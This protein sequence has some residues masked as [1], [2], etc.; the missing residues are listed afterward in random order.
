MAKR[1]N[2][3]PLG[4]KEPKPDPFSFAGESWREPER[5]ERRLR[6]V[7][8]RRNRSPAR[9][10][11]RRHRLHI[12]AVVPV[13][14]RPGFS[15]TTGL[16]LPQPKLR[17]RETPEPGETKVGSGFGLGSGSDPVM[18]VELPPLGE[19]ARGRTERRRR[20]VESGLRRRRRFEL[21]RSWKGRSERR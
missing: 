19:S 4:L 21:R 14:P 12:G 1:A 3:G 6:R 13:Q 8:S 17:R 20:R 16:A 5:R 9:S 18:A 7:P 15:P 2:H 10:G 11:P